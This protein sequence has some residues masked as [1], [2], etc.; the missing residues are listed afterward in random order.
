MNP[1]RFPKRIEN[2][3]ITA[4]I[5][6]VVTVCFMPTLNNGFVNWDDEVNY[7]EN[8]HY[9]GLS[10]R[11]L[12]W[13]FAGSF[14]SG[15][16]MPLT[17]L[18]LGLDYILW[19]M[20]PAGYHLTNLLLHVLNSLLFF[21][22]ILIFLKR[23]SGTPLMN[24]AFGIQVCAAVGA[25]FFAIHPLRVESVAW[26]TERRDVLSGF[27]YLLTVLAYLRMKDR[28]IKRTI[29]RRW[30]FL[31]LF[32]FIC[33]LLSKPWG[34]TLPVV[35]LILDIYPLG[36]VSG[37]R[38]RFTKLRKLSIEKIPYLL[39]SFISMGLTVIAEKQIVTVQSVTFHE[40]VARCMQAA[41]GLCFYLWKTLI[42]V[43][44][45]PIYLIDNPLNPYDFPYLF[46]ALAVLV[47][48]VSLILLRHRWPWALTAWICYAVIVSPFLGLFHRGHHIAADRYTYISCLP[49][50]VLV[51]AGMAMLRRSWQNQRIPSA[52][53]LW[54]VWGWVI[55]F[56][57]YS[58]LTVYQ[59]HVW[60]DSRSLWRHMLKL[61][62]EHYIAHN[63]MGDILMNDG[64]LND[65]V[66]HF[67]EAL[68]FNPDLW[69]AHINMGTAYAQQGKVEK[70]VFHYTE[71]IRINPNADEAYFN[72]GNIF[73]SRDRLELSITY[74]SMALEI[75]PGNASVHNNLGI[76]RMR[77]G[78]IK[79]AFEHFYQALQ[80][81]PDFE[82]A[83]S[84]MNRILEIIG[85]PENSSKILSGG[86]G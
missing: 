47:I 21:Y 43:R 10:L 66:T 37:N 71:S 73:A 5:A 17:W 53:K 83:H 23:F 22:L 28:E 59:I 49:F 6:L 13:M 69:P 68:R 62:P 4:I 8:L 29:R 57:T 67:A 76:A 33:S 45:S 48:T 74:Y 79:K 58:M 52:I 41:Y 61:D 72:L 84:N 25:L 26:L 31:S 42:P 86:H 65:A 77:Q 1:A 82:D 50:G 24:D 14:D 56:I 30:F 2:W 60:R 32:F 85:I 35:F 16:Y 12:S 27:F 36:L 7:T 3:H 44:L 34:I 80:I 11:H 46:C 64:R 38:E 78:Q 51:A 54:A 18:T 55:C 19:E 9:R 81:R 15:L 39:L 63:N 70:A 20:N 40:I 75:D